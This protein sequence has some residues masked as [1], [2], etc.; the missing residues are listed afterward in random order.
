MVMVSPKYRNVAIEVVLEM[1]TPSS[2]SNLRHPKT[3]EEV[4]KDITLAASD[5]HLNP[6]P[7]PNL[8]T[9]AK[10]RFP[11]FDTTSGDRHQKRMIKNRES[12]ARS[13]ARKQ[14]TLSLPLS[15]EYYNKK[16]LNLKVMVKLRNY[17]QAYTNELELEV[18]HLLQENAMLRKQQLEFY[19]EA[20]ADEHEKGKPLHRT[21]TAPF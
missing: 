4:W 1:W 3:M 12:A 11:E 10:K 16:N 20:A 14:E 19:S 21:S 9:S 6:S 5:L 2:S 7:P 18:A 13:R 17:V 8:T 15:L